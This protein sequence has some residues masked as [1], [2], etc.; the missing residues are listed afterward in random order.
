M[1]VSS[2]TPSV[3]MSSG[4]LDADLGGTGHQLGRR[5]GVEQGEQ[6][7]QRGRAE[8]FLIP[9]GIVE[10]DRWMHRHLQPAG[11]VVVGR[12]R[13]LRQRGGRRIPDRPVAGATAEVAAELVADLPWFLAT[14]A[15]VGLEHRDHEA[16][17]AVAA[18]RAVLLDHG[19]LHRVQLLLVG[20]APG[21]ALDG[22]DLA[23][24][25]HRHQRDAAVEC[26]VGR[27]ALCVAVHER[28]GARAA[29]ALGTAF[30][31]TGQAVG[32]Q[33]REQRGRGRHA[34]GGDGAAVDDQV[35]TGRSRR[36]SIK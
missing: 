23:A 7:G 28:H 29:V 16:G 12:G 13:T 25:E 6:A 21:Q 15:V 5:V 22:H 20:A 10:R 18:L 9:D 17:R 36:R 35:E 32:A 33:P 26:A 19:R 2:G 31:G 14:V 8:E 27:L 3:E 34:G 11:E 1:R 4:K 30:L 24:G